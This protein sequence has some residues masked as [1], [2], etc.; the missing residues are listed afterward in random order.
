MSAP[1]GDRPAVTALPA[2]LTSA[3]AAELYAQLSGLR[4]GPVALD[5]STVTA[6]GAQCLQ[7]L[8]AARQAWRESGQGF[9]L[10][11][12][13]AGFVAQLHLF[14]ISADAIGLQEDPE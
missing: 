11:G 2:R 5:A 7:V 14:G 9:V 10:F 13:S 6:L 12:A 8:V 3:R 1:A 4:G